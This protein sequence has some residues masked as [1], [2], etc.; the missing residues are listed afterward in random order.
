VQLWAAPVATPTTFTA[1][2]TTNADA[3][4]DFTFT[5][6]FEAGFNLYA[7][8]N[9]MVSP[10]RNLRITQAP[11]LT[12]GST[13]KGSVTVTVTGNPKTAGQ[14]AQLQ[15]AG[16]GGVWTTVASGVLSS[17]GVFSA[18]LT[19]LTSGSSI[20]YRAV[21]LATTSKGIL[22]GTSASKVIGVR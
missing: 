11:V 22:A 13:A 7:T 19:G 15:R 8:S 17:T 1:V 20:T 3:N 6:T 16:T 18:T 9:D 4:G 21:I 12:G 10:T 2:Q 14:T 5:R